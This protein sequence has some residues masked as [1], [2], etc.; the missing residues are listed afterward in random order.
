LTRFV[1]VARSVENSID[2][3]RETAQQLKNSGIMPLN[4]A[5]LQWLRQ[6]QGETPAGRLATRYLTDINTIKEEFANVAQGGYAPH[7]SVWKLANEQINAN[8]GVNQLGDSLDEIQ[9]LMRYRLQSIPN[10]E[11]M[12]PG[13]PNQYETG[14]GMPGG[15]GD[16]Q[17]PGPPPAPQAGGKGPAPVK[18]SSPEEASKLPSG[19][20]IILPDGRKGTVP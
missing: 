17:Q 7:E 13:S 1:G 6:F 2:R 5:K 14:V 10:M 20:P 19:T 3:V 4:A 9:R 11:Q 16:Q 8:Y 15:G 12:G 18:V